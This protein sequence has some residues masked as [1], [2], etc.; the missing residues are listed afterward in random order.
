MSSALLR[1]SVQ[2]DRGDS[3]LGGMQQGLIGLGDGGHGCVSGWRIQAMAPRSRRAWMSDRDQPRPVSSSSVC[4][5]GRGIGRACPGVRDS[6]APAP[7]AH[8]VGLDEAGARAVLRMVRGLFEIEHR[9]EAGVAAFEQRAPFVA[10]LAGDD[11][12]QP[13]P[14]RRPL[15]AVPLP[16][17]FRV[18]D[19]AAFQQQAVELRLD[20]AD[21][22]I[23][24]VGAGIAA[25]EVRAAI[26]HVGLPAVDPV[27]VAQLAVIGGGQQR[28]AVADR[29]V[30]HLALAAAAGLQQGAQ[31]AE[32]QHHRAAAHVADQVQRRAGGR[33]ASPMACSAPVRAM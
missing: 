28:G 14:Q 33:S 15:G 4:W 29:R 11:R 30:H 9:G 18:V 24:A 31:Q 20:R 10:R 27:A 8:A 6:R 7:V 12:R 25:V 5:P 19:A 13:G 21:R 26:Q 16:L 1:G 22:H 3:F 23:F 17:E 32:G 2:R